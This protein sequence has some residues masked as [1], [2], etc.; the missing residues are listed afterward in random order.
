MW[1]S[2]R[3]TATGSGRVALHLSAYHSRYCHTRWMTSSSRASVLSLRAEPRRATLS[4]NMLSMSVPSYPS[5]PMQTVR[6]GSLY[7]MCS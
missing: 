4:R 1:H 2:A 6:S 7:A 3:S 5:A